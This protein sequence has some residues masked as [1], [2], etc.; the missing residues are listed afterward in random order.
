MSRV[1][2]LLAE[3]DPNHQELAKLALEADHRAEVRC[4]RNQEEFCRAIREESFDC[5]LLDYRLADCRATEL[6]QLL[7]KE[8]INCPALVITSSTQQGPAVESW[9]NGCVDFVPKSEAFQGDALWGRIERALT[10]SRKARDERRK[11]D[12]R[13]KRL[14][15]LA[16]TDPLTGLLNRR[17]LQKT[18][19]TRRR[20]LDRR[21]P[22]SVLMLDIDHFKQINDT[23]GHSFGDQALRA[24]AE[25]L[26][27]AD[28]DGAQASRWGGE[29]F[30]VAMPATPHPQAVWEAEAFRR[31]IE[32]LGLKCDLEAVPVTVSIGVATGAGAET[33]DELIPAADQAMYL[34]KRSGR[35][36]VCTSEMVTFVNRLEQPEVAREPSPEGRLRR[37]LESSGELLGPTQREHLTSHAE[38]VSQLST[39]IAPIVGLDRQSVEQVRL[40]GLYHD[41]GKFVISEAVLAKKAPLTNEERGLLSRLTDDGADM[42]VRLGIDPSTADCIR[43]HHTRFD[44]MR[45]TLCTSDR[46]VPQGARILAVAD[47]FVSMASHRPYQPA[48]SFSAVVRELQ[49]CRGSQ[50]DPLV[51]D[52]VPRAILSRTAKRDWLRF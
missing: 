45:S 12:R 37:L 46:A 35:N 17:S 41:V 30:V 25:A 20:T 47:A 44:D 36:R 19:N 7:A 2:I 5:I 18:F 4:V 22:A 23:H 50:F 27:A 38:H 3:D 33:I 10:Q 49:R 42:G 26:R 43:H 13:L 21:G 28:R 31:K 40:A 6:L 11:V 32:G 24:V 29:E 16:E 48:R 52:A 51:V 1:R 34:A 8:A 14:S 39:W 15:K 9:R